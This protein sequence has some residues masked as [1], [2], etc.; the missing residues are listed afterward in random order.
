[1]S[2]PG[3]RYVLW[4]SAFEFWQAQPEEGQDRLQAHF[5]WLGDHPS[6][7]GFAEDYDALGRP[8][9]LSICDDYVVAHWA[10]HSVR[11]IQILDISAG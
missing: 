8:I 1:V 5:E 4:Q 10:D 7:N 9:F 6:H 3:Y 2:G 11:L